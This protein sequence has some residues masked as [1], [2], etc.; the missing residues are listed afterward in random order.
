MVMTPLD[1]GVTGSIV[2]GRQAR[3]EMCGG[4]GM[5]P[6]STRVGGATHGG[7][8]QRIVGISWH[9]VNLLDYWG[10]MVRLTTSPACTTI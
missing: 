2:R 10:G 1:R 9:D 3:V 5:R 7:F 8:G 4:C 6:V